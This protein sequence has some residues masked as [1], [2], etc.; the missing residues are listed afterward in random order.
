MPRIQNGPG[1]RIST[2]AI[3]TASW[4]RERRTWRTAHVRVEVSCSTQ[5]A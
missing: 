4:T 1:T 3:G 5:G 2:S